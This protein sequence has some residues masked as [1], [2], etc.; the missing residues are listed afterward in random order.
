[1]VNRQYIVSNGMELITAPEKARPCPREK[2]LEPKT[3]RFICIKAFLDV[4]AVSYSL[5]LSP[6]HIF[7][8]KHDPGNA[9]HLR[10]G[11]VLCVRRLAMERWR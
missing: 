9:A 1:M 10:P 6:P 8:L 4:L 11:D 2:S 5:F 7:L 3:W